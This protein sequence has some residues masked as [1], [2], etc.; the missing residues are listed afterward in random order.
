MR[1]KRKYSMAVSAIALAAAASLLFTACSASSAA[2]NTTA[3]QTMDAAGS[4]V[5]AIAKSEENAG[6]AGSGADTA[7]AQKALSS[8]KIIERLNYHMETLEFDK[9]IQTLQTLT[10][11]LGG[12]IQESGVDGDG[13]LQ[14]NDSRTAHYVLRIPQEK[15]KAWKEQSGTIGSVLNVSSSSENI[16]ESYY[17]TEAHLSALR[18]QQT[19]LLEL[20]KKADKMA[21]IVELEKAL[22]DVTYQIEQLTGTLRQYD[23]LVNY[24]TITVDLYEVS[25]AT[26]IDKTPVTL[27]EK[28]AYQFRQSLRWLGDA[29]EGALVVV[30]GG[31]PILL[32]IAV[33]GGIVWLVTRRKKRRA[34][35]AAPPKDGEEDGN[36]PKLPPQE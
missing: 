19:R 30:I 23:S 24:S 16:T 1:T 4:S 12:Y 34:Q 26:I 15:L 9:S 27:G 21:D 18:T 14:K 2:P 22:A 17:D 31:L 36:P 10:E 32:L 11:Q 29:G 25:K 35:P 13:A 5:T 3:A 20:M 8:Q 28:I 6:V 33:A 7:A